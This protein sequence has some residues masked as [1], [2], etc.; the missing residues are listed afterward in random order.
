MEISEEVAN[1]FYEQV[2]G[3]Y[4]GH[5]SGIPNNPALYGL[6][7]AHDVRQKADFCRFLEGIFKQLNKS[8]GF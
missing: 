5:M 8:E 2:C 7:Q 6:M 3:Q 4:S 1:Y